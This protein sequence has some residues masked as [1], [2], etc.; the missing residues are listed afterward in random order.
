MI[1]PYV[2]ENGTLKNKLGIE[3]YEELRKALSDPDNINYVIVG[4]LLDEIKKLDDMLLEERII[5][6]HINHQS[7]YI[8]K[9]QSIIRINEL[10]RVGYSVYKPVK[11]ISKKSKSIFEHLF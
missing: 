5:H 10:S 3:D 1:D 11:V 2:L 4:G 8:K 9:L 7:D 6:G